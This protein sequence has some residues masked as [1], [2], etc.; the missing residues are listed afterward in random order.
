MF[1]VAAFVGIGVGAMFATHHGS[2]DISFALGS[3]PTPVVSVAPPVTST[4][5]T[6]APTQT[7]S[8]SVSPSVTATPSGPCDQ[9]VVAWNGTGDPDQEARSAV[10]NALV[11]AQALHVA[12]QSYANA[13]AEGLCAAEQNYGFTSE[14][15]TSASVVSVH[16]EA[17]V[18]SAAARSSTGACYWIKV[19]DSTGATTYGRGEPCTGQAALGAA[20]PSW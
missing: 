8:A 16:A 17:G 18:F 9:R 20:A 15:S 7:A 3:T 1:S 13:T 2:R 4:P 12:S 19:D 10:S 6:V 5:P 11:D 14:A